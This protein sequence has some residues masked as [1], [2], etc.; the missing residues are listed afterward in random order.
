MSHFLL[1][2]RVEY[3]H[4]TDPRVYRVTLVKYLCADRFYAL[5]EACGKEWLVRS[6]RLRHIGG[7]PRQGKNAA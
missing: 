6:E 5:V 4:T 3:Q 2:Q 7:C 1:G